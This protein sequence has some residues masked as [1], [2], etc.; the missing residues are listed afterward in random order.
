M[1]GGKVRWRGELVLRED[2]KTIR[3]NSL[4]RE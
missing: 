3:N 4:R 2:D 1:N